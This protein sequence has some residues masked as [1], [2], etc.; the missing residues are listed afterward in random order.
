MAVAATLSV[1]A[2]VA[3]VEVVASVAVVATTAAVAIVAAVAVVVGAAT[4]N[5]CSCDY[6]EHLDPFR[7]WFLFANLFSFG[8]FSTNS[9]CSFF[10]SQQKLP[11]HVE[12]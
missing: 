1:I 6:L 3:T 10:Q 12:S 8:I 4:R 5:C 11:K 9:R 7:L 2:V